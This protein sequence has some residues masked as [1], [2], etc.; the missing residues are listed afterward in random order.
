MNLI[1]VCSDIH[2]EKGDIVEINFNNIIQKNAEIL[3]LAGDIGDP[4]TDIYLNF[5]KFCSELFIHV[6]VISG[7][8]EYYNYS[9]E[10]VDD[11]I[12]KIC[13]NFINVHY[14]NNK[15]F[16]YEGLLFIGSTL[17]SSISPDIKMSDLM[18]IKDYHKIKN[19]SPKISN[20]L[21]N[22]NLKFIEDNLN[23]NINC[24]VISHHAPSYKCIPEEYK[25]DS[26]NCCYASHLD[27]LFN[28]TNLLG[29][30]YGHTHYNYIEYSENKF[31][32]ANCYRT[33]DYISNGTVL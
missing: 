15:T 6:L 28:N 20:D 33:A 25:G 8:H 4:F 9:I 29:W 16:Y 24:I 27:Y 21:F 32:Y 23:N 7:N 18:T 3:V 13:N 5:I 2:F 30:I 14:L 31:L 12:N 19:F 1:Q 22:K 26:V 11:K 17:W 10:E